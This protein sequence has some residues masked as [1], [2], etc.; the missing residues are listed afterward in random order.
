[1][2]VNGGNLL[3][4][5]SGAP[6][7]NLNRQGVGE[8]NVYVNPDDKLVFGEPGDAD[9]VYIDTSGNVGIGTTE[10]SYK[11]DVSGATRIHGYRL[12]V[13]PP[14]S[15]L[16]STQADTTGYSWT[17]MIFGSNHGTNEFG[18]LSIGGTDRFSDSPMGKLGFHSF[19][20]DNKL[21]TTVGAEIRALSDSSVATDYG[22]HLAFLTRES[23][24]SLTERVRILSNGNVGIG[25]TS[26]SEKLDV[27]G[28]IIEEGTFAEIYVN[29]ASASQTISSSATYTKVTAFAT[30]GQS[31]NCTADAAND[32][33]TITKAGRYFVSC[34][35]DGYIDSNNVEFDAAIFLNG[36]IQNN[37]KAKVEFQAANKE[38]QLTLV[39]IVDVTS[40]GQDLDVRI[41]QQSGS[42]VTMTM[43]NTNLNVHYLGET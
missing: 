14:Q 37:L 5:N 30:N 21:A 1:L 22:M 25:T 29:D 9:H 3:I 42:N 8:W 18:S 26:P 11:L 13:E 24:G 35:L 7:L 6:K 10:P 38:G 34:Q 33:I 27:N 39:G 12:I 17:G 43:V 28:R 23:G 40:D 31:S 4:N 36:N 15:S 41:R 20:T 16:T 2:E 19:N 32:K